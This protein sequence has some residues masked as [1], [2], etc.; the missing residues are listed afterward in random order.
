[1]TPDDQ[2]DFNNGKELYAI[3]EEPEDDKLSVKG[4]LK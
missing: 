4:P 3:Q 2:D 1:M